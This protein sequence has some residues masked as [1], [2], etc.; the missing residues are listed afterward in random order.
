M[1]GALLLEDAHLLDEPGTLVL[2]LP[3]Q[4]LELVDELV[5]LVEGAAHLA[6]HAVDVDIHGTLV[7][8]RLL[9]RQRVHLPEH[10]DVVDLEDDLADL[11]LELAQL[12]V[13]QHL[14][15][16][17]GEL[18]RVERLRQLLELLARQELLARGAQPP[19]RHL[20]L[21]IDLLRLEHLLRVKGEG[22]GEGER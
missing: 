5:A 13:D 7:H 18:D 15:V 4:D 17:E 2:L 16:L 9:A 12:G 10:A 6:R 22:W 20:E 21:E 11:R 1:R 14:A 3:L 8:R 19:P